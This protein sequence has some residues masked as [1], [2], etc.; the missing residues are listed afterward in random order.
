MNR[1]NAARI[2]WM[3][4]AR[5]RP[6]SVASLVRRVFLDPIWPK[7]FH[8]TY[9]K[10]R[11]RHESFFLPPLL[12]HVTDVTFAWLDQN[13]LG[14]PGEISRWPDRISTRYGILADHVDQLLPPPESGAPYILLPIIESLH[15]L[16]VQFFSKDDCQA[17]PY[18]C[19]RYLASSFDELEGRLNCRPPKG[20]VEHKKQLCPREKDLLLSSLR[21]SGF[22]VFTYKL[23]SC[24][25]PAVVFPGQ[26][27]PMGDQ[28]K[29]A[30]QRILS[31]VRAALTKYLEDVEDYLE[32]TE[33]LPNGFRIAR[34]IHL[35]W[36]ARR[37][38]APRESVEGIALD[39]VQVPVKHKDDA[40]DCPSTHP[41]VVS[42]ATR[43][44]AEFLGLELPPRCDARPGHS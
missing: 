11:K 8:E 4:V 41:D 6:R 42:D 31:E 38:V 32:T 35:D 16:W 34:P 5:S 37:L 18:E 25:H 1:E 39:P 30:R 21:R 15:D 14:K 43:S 22:P 13:L 29:D 24:W 7:L 28:K 19:A 33:A 27:H 44:L 3:Y 17:D 26:L 2:L 9:E 20:P 40:E 10:W 36:L 23:E 12:Y